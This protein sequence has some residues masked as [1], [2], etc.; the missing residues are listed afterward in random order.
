M[1]FS[2]RA[3]YSNLFSTLVSRIN[4]TIVNISISDTKES[5]GVAAANQASSLIRETLQEKEHI[6]IILA[7]G[8]SQFEVLEHLVKANIP[9]EKVTMFHLDEY[10]GMPDSHPA[11]FRKYLTERFLEKIDFRCTYHL[12]DGEGNPEQECDRISSIITEHPIDVALIG[13]GENAHLAF[14]R[15]SCRL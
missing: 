1:S 5:L 11:S 9:W 13:I 12:I 4:R 8:A 3:S 2:S 14:K 15:S 7:T 10:I 6:N